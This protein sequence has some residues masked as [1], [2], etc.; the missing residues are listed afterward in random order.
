[1]QKMLPE[2]DYGI[3]NKK[4]E[5]LAGKCLLVRNIDTGI[6]YICLLT[7][8]CRG[9]HKMDIGKQGRPKSDAKERVV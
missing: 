9:S 2:Y 7:Y 8:L 1:M 6:N 5:N 4:Y 3:Y